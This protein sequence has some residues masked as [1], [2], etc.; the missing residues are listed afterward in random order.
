MLDNNINSVD[1]ADRSLAR[2]MQGR[3]FV[4][5]DDDDMND[6]GILDG[7][8]GDNV[9]EPPN[10]LVQSSDVSCSATVTNNCNTFAPAYVKPFYDLSG[11]HEETS[12]VLNVNVSVDPI[13]EDP[14]SSEIQAFFNF[15]NELYEAEANF[16]T[17]YLN[18][19]YQYDE[20]ADRDPN[21]QGGLFGIVDDLNGQ[22]ALIFME[23]TRTA[24]I[25]N[26]AGRPVG[27]A[28]IVVHELGHLF[29]G[30]HEDY[31]PIGTSNP[32]PA[33][34]GLMATTSDRTSGIFNDVT[35]NKI[36]GGTFV[37][38]GITRRITHP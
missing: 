7:D 2:K 11:S 29:N 10:S 8:E 38:N 20:R 3:S 25:P 4:L 5:Y 18:G 15:N 24:E 27:R 21:N 16:W 32:N 17:V 19:A 22:G 30:K 23:T 13:R 6:D 12:F 1:L 14:P 26:P 34:A 33:T 36:R 31:F 9:E 37:E 28:Y 35:I